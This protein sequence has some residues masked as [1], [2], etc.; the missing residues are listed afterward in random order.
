MLVEQRPRRAKELQ[1]QIDDVHACLGQCQGCV[2]SANERRVAHPDMSP[3]TLDLSISRLIE[4]AESIAPLNRV[5]V[6]FGIADHLI[7]PEEYVQALHAA[8]ARIVRAG[9]PQD[10]EHSAV[11]FSTSLVGKPTEVVRKLSACRS[12]E[13]SDVPLLPIVVLDPRLLH[14]VKFGPAYR[15]MI[16][17]AKAIFG[18]VDLTIN[19][20][21]EAVSMMGPREFIEFAVINGFDEVTVNWTPTLGNAAATCGNLPALSQWLL[22]FDDEMRRNPGITSSF[23]P[24]LRGAIDVAMCGA[25]DDSLPSVMQTVMNVFP[26]TVRKSIQVDNFGNLVPKLEAI[27]DVPHHPRF[28]LP[29]IG[30][31]RE[32]SIAEL[33]D[34][35]MPAMQRRIIATHCKGPCASCPVAGICAATG[36]H[37]LTHV[38]RR[39]G[40]AAEGRCPHVARDLIDRLLLEARA[41][42]RARQVA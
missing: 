4:Y 9:R 10:R 39:T 36:F 24:V 11:F 30:N 42:D 34:R 26:E 2:L 35:R 8:A 21:D 25:D 1:I 17:E 13:A 15:E 27:G 37:V 23:H 33:I 20:S 12:P 28:G 14:A 22:G 31:L 6:T 16:T 38:M 41:A 29:I 40:H 18:K 32:A 3:A 7:M 5:N 19:L